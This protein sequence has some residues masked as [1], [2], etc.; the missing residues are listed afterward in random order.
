MH[1][2]VGSTNPVKI[3]ATTVAAA[4]TWP[5]IKVSGFEV[6]SGVSEQPITDQETKTGAIN[7]AQAVLQIGLKEAVDSK[8][9]LGVG[10]EGG[11]FVD[12]QNQT[13]TTVWAAVV[14]HKNNLY[15]ANGA[16]FPVPEIVAKQIEAGEEM[17]PI[18]AS[19]FNGRSIKHQEGMIGV[20]TN[21]FVDRTEEYS[22]I[23]KMALGLWYGRTWQKDLGI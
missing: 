9:I 2:F 1:I 17:G 11:V 23:I 13:W 22:A 7:R 20:V 16:R 19:F 12:D 18:M 6:M 5:K 15:I 4:E 10:L 14:D 8:D 21:N 3:N